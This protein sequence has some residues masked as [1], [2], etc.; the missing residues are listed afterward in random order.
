MSGHQGQ[1][2]GVRLLRALRAPAPPQPERCAFC[3]VALVPG[4]RHLADTEERALV[5]A[6]TACSLLFQRPGAG[7]GRYRAV[8]DRYLTDPGR[9]PGEDVWTTLCI[10]VSTAFVLHNTALGHP[11]LCYPS[12]AGAT[13]SEL[14]E[15]TWRSVFA[16]NRLAAV[17]EPD[18]E[19]LLL[20]RPR[21]E[22]GEYHCFLVPVDI[23][24]ELVGRM[25]LHWRGFDGGTE[26][27]REL[28]AFFA[29]VA[30]RARP[31]PKE[32]AV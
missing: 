15:S 1:G 7:D 28:D 10:P 25:R 2:A 11:V 20:R 17:L 21:G 6:C 22:R 8:P 31:L 23:C 9:E 13:E 24:Y 16:D 27:H 26:A 3:A 19:A 18:V 5:C 32:V 29:T 14:D 4:H 12:P 30:D